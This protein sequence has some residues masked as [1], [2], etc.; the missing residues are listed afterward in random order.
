MMGIATR[1][2]KNSEASDSA[3]VLSLS[4]FLMLLAFFIVLS[5]F[6]DFEESKVVAVQ[7]SVEEAFASAS[8]IMGVDGKAS[9][10]AGDDFS[11]NTGQA[12]D[13]IENLFKSQIGLISITRMAQSNTMII[14]LPEKEIFESHLEQNNTNKNLATEVAQIINQAREKEVY[15]HV[16]INAHF[17]RKSQTPMQKVKGVGAFARAL[18]SQKITPDALS[19]GLNNGKEGYVDLIFKTYKSANDPLLNISDEK[20]LP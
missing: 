5:T 4:L 18:I 17:N 19:I 15:F 16:Q 7:N 12:F 3:Q 2:N 9:D 14:S 20:V 10:V 8:D 6:S 11:V 13:D 1:K